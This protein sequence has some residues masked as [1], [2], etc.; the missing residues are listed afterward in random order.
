MDAGVPLA[1]VPAGIAIGLVK[2]GDRHVVLTDIAGVEDHFGD[3]DFK[4]AGTEKGVTAMQVDLKIREISVD[5]CREALGKARA[6]RLKVLESMKAALP[7]PRPEI[8]PYAP[9]IF[10][11]YINPEKVG[12]VIG[13]A[14]KV[15]KRIVAATKAK[16]DV[17]ETGKIII[18]STDSEAAEKAK[19]M[20]HDITAEAEVGKTYTGKVVRIEEYGAFVEIMP[21]LV[22]LMHVSEIAPYRIRSVSDVLKVGDEV[23]VKVLTVEDNRIRLSRRALE[24]DEKPAEGGET[25]PEPRPKK[26][27]YRPN[28]PDRRDRRGGGGG[29]RGRY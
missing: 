28:R 22:G 29:S 19:Q 10:Y 25:G 2:E 6:A 16:I 1:F 4:V 26:Q 8:S 21:N 13:P 12:D 11:L 23:T 5:L 7:A 17:D 3:M 20:I 24:T 14:G 27:G 15:I 9:R 18:A